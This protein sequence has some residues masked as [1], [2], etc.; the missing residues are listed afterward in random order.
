MIISRITFLLNAV[1]YQPALERKCKALLTTLKW[2]IE[3]CM[4]YLRDLQ[5][6]L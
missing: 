4:S 5:V 1:Y 6:S 3:G 2:N